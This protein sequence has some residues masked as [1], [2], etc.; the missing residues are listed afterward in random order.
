MDSDFTLEEIKV[1]IR[2]FPNGKA[3]CI[4]F[5]KAHVDIV[6]PLL[7][8]LVNCSLNNGIFPKT[9]YDAH[10]CLILKKDRDSLSLTPYHPLSLLNSDQKIIA[11]VLSNRLSND[12]GALI[13]P[14]QTGFILDRF[15]FSNTHRILKIIYAHNKPYSA[16]DRS[17]PF[18][19]QRGTR[20]GCCH[21]PMFFALALEPFAVSIRTCPKIIGI[22]CSSP[23]STIGLYADDVV[24]TLSDVKTSLSPLL[25][26]IRAFGQ[27]SGFTINWDKSFLMPLS[28][29]LDHYFLSKFPFKISDD[30][31]NYL[32]I[33]I[34]RNP[35]LLY[36]FNYLNTNDAIKTMIE[37]WKLLPLSLIGRINIIKM[38]VLSKFTYI[39]QNVP[40]F[41]TSSF[42]KT[43]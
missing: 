31:F 19:L 43:T 16:I 14:D 18:A 34:T 21:S 26:L 28:D 27:L 3:F 13:H 32:G 1:A 2:S 8:R 7:L 42:F 24:L 15:P 22:P 38:I 17:P 4:E 9:L 36:K 30:K 40:I 11:K 35:K 41:L 25:D 39:Y 29:G 10:I 20:Q 37:K 6:A 23:I 12:L 5:Y 33:N